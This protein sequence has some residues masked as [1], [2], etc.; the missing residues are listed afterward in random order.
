MDKDQIIN[1]LSGMLQK[2]NNEIINLELQIA[3]LTEQVNSAKKEEQPK[4]AEEKSEK[5]K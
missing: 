2:R 4:K 5:N 1:S 3:Q